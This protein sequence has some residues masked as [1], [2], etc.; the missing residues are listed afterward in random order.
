MLSLLTFVRS[1]IGRYLLIGMAL[2][3]LIGGIYLKGRTDMH[4]ADVIVLQK[5]R[6]ADA[7]ALNTCHGNVSTLQGALDRQGAA[8]SAMKADSD[9]RGQMLAD[10]LQS[11]RKA[12]V[13]AQSK[14]DRILALKPEGSDQCE[15]VRAL[16]RVVNGG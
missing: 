15:A 12:A 14:A 3:A 11:A 7:L 1:P 2:F 10:A 16:D 4:K 13:A 9:R 8:V 5:V 6:D